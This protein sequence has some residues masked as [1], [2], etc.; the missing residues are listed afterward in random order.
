MDALQVIGLVESVDANLPIAGEVE[1]E[2][3]HQG[4][5]VEAVCFDQRPHWSEV[6]AQGRRVVR[7]ADPDHAAPFLAGHFAQMETLFDEAR[8]EGLAV[9]DAGQYA[10]GPP[11]PPMIRTLEG[12]RVPGGRLTETPAAVETDVVEGAHT[13]LLAYNQIRLQADVEGEI[14]TGCGEITRQTRHQPDAR[15]QL[16]HLCAPILGRRVALL[17]DRARRAP[18]R[19]H[20]RAHVADAA[21]P[22]P[23][24]TRA[25]AFRCGRGQAAPT[26]CG[27]RATASHHRAPRCA[28]RPRAAGSPVGPGRTGPSPDCRRC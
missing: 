20:P 18:L 21:P 3:L 8:F 28:D 14:R 6:I 4:V 11:G 13:G 7:G 27:C 9:W 24:I 25:A 10:V 16:F 2:I 12:F 23:S 26:P 17:R 1:G 15:P 22:A 5:V 19:L